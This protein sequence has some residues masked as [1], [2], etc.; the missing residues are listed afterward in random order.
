MKYCILLITLSFALKLSAQQGAFVGQNS[1]LHNSNGQIAGSAPVSGVSQLMDVY[2]YHIPRYAQ[3]TIY[4][5]CGK[6]IFS[7]KG[8]DAHILNQLPKGFY[9]LRVYCLTGTWT[10]EIKQ[11]D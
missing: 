10:I 8:K 4:D 3:F 6:R 1:M 11:E 9:F 2:Q 5:A 7:G